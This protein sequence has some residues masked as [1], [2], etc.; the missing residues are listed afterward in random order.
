MVTI[1]WVSSEAGRHAAANEGITVGEDLARAGESTIDI[2]FFWTDTQS[3]DQWI[4]Q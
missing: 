2:Y 1:G 3:F 4:G